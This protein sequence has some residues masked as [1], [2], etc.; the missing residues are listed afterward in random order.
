MTMAGETRG[1]A[2]RDQH[3]TDS[4]LHARA[5]ARAQGG[6]TQPWMPYLPASTSPFPPAGSRSGH[7]DLGR[8]GRAA[9][10]TRT[11]CS[12]PARGCASTT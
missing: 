4:V 1:A 10:A 9:A 7:A 2:P 11:R 5:D 8:D 3:V 6:Q 12:P